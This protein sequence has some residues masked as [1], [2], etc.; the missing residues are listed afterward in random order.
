MV[1]SFKGNK[2]SRS[3]SFDVFKLVCK[4]VS[5]HSK[6]SLG[7]SSM[8]TRTFTFSSKL[9]P[10]IVAWLLMVQPAKIIFTNQ[11]HINFNEQISDGLNIPE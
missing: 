5:L 7:S 3:S 2:P 6:V 1:T 11:E 9:T 8:H 10:R 4:T